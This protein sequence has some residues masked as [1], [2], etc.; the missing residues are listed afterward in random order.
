MRNRKAKALVALMAAA[1]LLVPSLARGEAD[2]SAAIPSRFSLGAGFGI[3]FG[4]IGLSCEVSPVLG[5][6]PDRIANH[7]SFNLGLGTS[8]AGIGYSLGFRFY[9]LGRERIWAPK[10]SLMYG[11]VCIVNWT[12]SYRGFAAGA[13]VVRRTGKKSSVDADVIFIINRFGYNSSDWGSGR[14]K[15]SIGWRRNFD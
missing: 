3:P 6:R 14:L 10:V 4:V 1:V 8:I 13:G 12:Y 2:G 5:S 9:P 11:T 7:L 15:F